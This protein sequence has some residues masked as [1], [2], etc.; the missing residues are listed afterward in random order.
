MEEEWRWEQIFSTSW[1]H[2][3]SAFTLSPLKIGLLRQYGAPSFTPI[4]GAEPV[5][6]FLFLFC[7]SASI[8][9]LPEFP[10]QNSSSRVPFRNSL[11]WFPLLYPHQN[12]Q[13]TLQCHLSLTFHFFKASNPTTFIQGPQML[14]NSRIPLSGMANI[15]PICE[16]PQKTVC[17]LCFTF[18]TLTG[19]PLLLMLWYIYL[20]STPWFF[21]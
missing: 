9:P 2:F 7:N 20:P 6:E 4:K 18:T 21:S 15:Q 17:S 1:F 11:H 14:S 8:I 5:L 16:L 12:Q 13:L 3:R 10:F 19:A